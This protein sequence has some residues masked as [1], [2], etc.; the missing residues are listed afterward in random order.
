M[1]DGR[2]F[3]NYR[4][5]CYLNNQL[6]QQSHTKSSY[7]YRQYLIQNGTKV[8]RDI[9][10]LMMDKNYCKGN[11]NYGPQPSQ[12]C[13]YNSVTKNCSPINLSGIGV[14]NEAVKANPGVLN[15]KGLGYSLN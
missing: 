5:S 10:R 4:S 13:T 8:M 7:A 1:S 2:A 11:C 15:P 6:R 14:K 9:N 3:T 12:T